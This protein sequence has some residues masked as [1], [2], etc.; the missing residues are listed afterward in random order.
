MSIKTKDQLIADIG[1]LFADN[2]SGD[3]SAL[4]LRTYLLTN[5]DS[6]TVQ[7]RQGVVS[8]DPVVNFTVA[9][10]DQ[11]LIHDMVP[12][13]LVNQTLVLPEIVTEM[14][15][16]NLLIVCDYTAGQTANIVASGSD[17]IQGDTFVD[18]FQTAVTARA[19][20][21][22]NWLIDSQLINN[23]DAVQDS[24]VA[25]SFANQVPTAV[26]VPLQVEFGPQQN[27]PTDDVQISAAG[28]ITFNRPG[29]FLTFLS[30]YFDR[31]TTQGTVQFAVRGLIDGTIQIGNPI[32]I[33]SSD[34]NST[35]PI[36]VTGLVKVVAAGTFV[37][38]ECVRDSNGIDNG[39]LSGFASS[40]GWGN[41]PS[42]RIRIVKIQ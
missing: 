26:D 8:A 28:T 2:A 4:D 19:V 6:L 31:T 33:R 16:I 15:G 36:F 3:I 17:V 41:T 22:G 11:N 5:L 35:V 32:G 34:A 25:E 21:L 13:S 29:N 39:Q 12:A 18:S 7:R 14:I 42:A 27:G 24:L 38:V 9:D 37:T 30:L 20:S 1:L 23:F 40:V 10:V